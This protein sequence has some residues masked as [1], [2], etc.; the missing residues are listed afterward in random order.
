M[1]NPIQSIRITYDYSKK[2]RD[3][4]NVLSNEDIEKML[5]TLGVPQEEIEKYPRYQKGYAAE[6]LFMRIYS[7]LPWIKNIVSLGQEQFP[8][9]SKETTQVSDYLVTYEVGNSSTTSTILLEAKL[10]DGNKSTFKLQNYKYDVLKKYSIDNNIPLLF[11]LFW[12][13]K[14]I[15]TINAIS[16]FK[17]LSSEYKIT[18]SEA[19]ESDL[20]AIFGDY[21]YVFDKSFYRKSVFNNASSVESTYFS[22]HEELGR[23]I[24]EETSVDGVSYKRLDHLFS[25]VIDCIFDMREVSRKNLT[26]TESEIVEYYQPSYT[27][28]VAIK[29]STLMYSYLVKLWQ[30]NKDDLYFFDSDFINQTFDIVDT[31][32]RNIGGERYYLLPNT[33]NQIHEDLMLSQFGAVRHL[34]NAYHFM[35]RKDECIICSAHNEDL[36][37]ILLKIKTK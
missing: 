34:I 11:A 1:G 24:L 5:N 21:V 29:L 32:R 2:A 15:W 19:V 17:Q 20:S 14:E 9:Q 33:N 36:P 13:E 30:I 31:A 37:N 3:N 16:V 26:L 18:Y 27:N 25:P 28:I 10:V 8:E 12:R 35:E 6:D 4:G 7:L 22:S 23:T